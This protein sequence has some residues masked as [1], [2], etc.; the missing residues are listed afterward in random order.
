[1]FDGSGSVG[2]TEDSTKIWQ[3][4]VVVAVMTG[5][6]ERIMRPTFGSDVAQAASENINDA[7]SAIKQGVTLAF[8]R[9]L[10]ELTF[11]GL[12]GFIDPYDGYLVIQITYNYRA[13]NSTRTVNIKT[14]VLSRSGDIIR[15][16]AKND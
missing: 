15:E 6:N 3:D 13:Q 2:Y 9:W 14:A 7:L 10:P 1:M 8:S 11:M 16:V 5:F 4:R 12:Q